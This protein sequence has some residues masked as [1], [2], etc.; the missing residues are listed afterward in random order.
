MAITEFAPGAEKTK[1]KGKYRVEGLT[2]PMKEEAD[3]QGNLTFYDTNGD[4][5]SDR[6]ILTFIKNADNPDNNIKEISEAPKDVQAKDIQ[7]NET[8]KL[9]VI[10]QAYR[11]IDIKGNFGTPIENN[12]RGSSFTQ[13]VIYARDNSQVDEKI[14][15]KEVCNVDISLYE[16]GLNEDPTVWHVN[17]NNGKFYSGSYTRLPQPPTGTN[18]NFMFYE[19]HAQDSISS[20]DNGMKIALGAKKVTE[21]VKLELKKYPNTLNLSLESGNKSAIRAAFYSAAFLLQRAL[22]DKLDVQPDEIEKCEKIDEEHEYPSI[23]L[24]DALPNGA[25]IVSY[26]YQDGNL[27]NLIKRIVDFDTFDPFKTSK[28]ESFMQSLI[29]EDHRDTCLTACQKCLLAYNNRGFHHVLDWRLGV[30]I[31]RLMIN[32]DY[33]FGYTV[34][35]RN[36][37]EELKDWDN[38]L[39]ACA[40][41]L[42]LTQTSSG[43]NLWKKNGNSTIIYHPLWKKEKL[44]EDLSISPDTATM[45]NSFKVLRS[46]LTNDGEMNPNII[47]KNKPAF[48]KKKKTKNDT[49][50]PPDQTSQDDGLVL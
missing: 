10:P 2:I 25:G 3:S 48:K 33:D 7:L 6:Y 44:F 17:S 49:E 31:L 23:Y 43:Q 15:K 9:I 14:T 32:P 36:K 18:S 34:S 24:S 22:A 40:K 12:D 26:L 41:K 21:M 29:S 13:S 42:F 35:D 30:G 4:A 47:K 11:S 39:A 27:E 16:L 38:I 28:D 45:Y 20:V 8:Q 19:K 5:L 50:T 37:Y 1:D 46:D